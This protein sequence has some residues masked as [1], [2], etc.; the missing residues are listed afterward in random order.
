ME[1]VQFSKNGS[2]LSGLQ[3]K[4]LDQTYY[5]SINGNKFNDFSVFVIIPFF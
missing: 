5:V 1:A 2:V 3:V 4:C